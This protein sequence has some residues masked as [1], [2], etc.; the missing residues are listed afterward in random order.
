M[1]GTRRVSSRDADRMLRMLD[2][3]QEWNPPRRPGGGP[4]LSA[5]Q[6]E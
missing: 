4:Y 3:L 6:E 2:I 1:H 5:T